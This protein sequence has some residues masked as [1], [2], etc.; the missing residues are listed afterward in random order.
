MKDFRSA[1]LIKLIE[2]VFLIKKISDWDSKLS[3]CAGTVYELNYK[4]VF[5][6][7]FKSSPNLFDRF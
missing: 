5:I 2:P 1:K 7:N 6:D 4:K 3:F